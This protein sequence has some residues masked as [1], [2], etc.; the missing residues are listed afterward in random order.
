MQNL[1]HLIGA[2]R[3]RL[4]TEDLELLDFASRPLDQQ[5]D[6]MQAH[7]AEQ[8]DQAFDRVL[9]RLR[10]EQGPELQREYELSS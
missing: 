8:Y 7:H 4:S 5:S 1:T 3:R 10:H 6:R 2:V 9:A